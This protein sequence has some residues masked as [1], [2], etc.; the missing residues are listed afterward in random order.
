MYLIDTNVHVAY[1][2]QR[3]ELD[4]LSIKYVKALEKI[5]LSERVVADIIFAELDSVLLRV[6]PVKYCLSNEDKVKLKKIVS[7]YFGACIDNCVLGVLSSNVIEQAVSLYRR[8]LED[9]YISFVDAMLLAMAK[10]QGY[11]LMTMDERLQKKA[12]LLDIEIYEV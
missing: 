3:Y 1:V 12:V 10:S 7:R 2:L 11:V 5:L 8:F 9:G 6:A 4:G